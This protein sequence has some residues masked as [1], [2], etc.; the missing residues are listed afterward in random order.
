M[1]DNTSF[2]NN[3]IS[4]NSTTNDPGFVSV[5]VSPVYSLLKKIT[6]LPSFVF[7]C[8]SSSLNH[9]PFVSIVD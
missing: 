6:L 4:H 2:H 9:Y 5:V 8:A 3:H 7:I 1:I